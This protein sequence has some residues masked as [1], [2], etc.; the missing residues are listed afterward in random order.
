MADEVLATLSPTFDQMYSR[1]GRL[2][3]PPER[4]LKGELLIALY[5]VRS[6][7]LFCEQLN[8]DILFRWFLDMNLDEPGFDHSTFNQNSERR[9]RHEVASGSLPQWSATPGARGCS[10]MS[11]APWT[12]H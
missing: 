10:R 8:W 5:S 2:S 4:L 1:T 12:A 3:V 9:L 6:R 11:T 7:R